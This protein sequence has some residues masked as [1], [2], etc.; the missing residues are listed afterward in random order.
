MIFE[1]LI[2][3]LVVIVDGI[4]SIISSAPVVSI[5]VDLIYS[6]AKVT[7]YGNWII[8]ADLMLLFCANVMFW[9]VVKTAA[10]LV[11]FV[12]RLVPFV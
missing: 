1:F 9:I 5:P 4:I 7:V 8:G 12:Y 11:L 10:G 3:V 2:N 6:V